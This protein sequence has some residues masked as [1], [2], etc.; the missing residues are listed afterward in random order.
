MDIN[1]P[2]INRE[3]PPQLTMPLVQIK[4]PDQ[5]LIPFG[6]PKWSIER[7]SVV[8]VSTTGTYL[9]SDTPLAYVDRSKECALRLRDFKTVIPG[10]WEDGMD[11][12]AAMRVIQQHLREKCELATSSEK[13]FLDLYFDYCREC[14]TPPDYIERLYE[15]EDERPVP[16]NNMDWMFDAM[17]PLPQAHLYQNDPL[18]DNFHFAP[19]RMMK[20]DF[21]FWTG[22]R[23]IAVEI[24]GSSHSG[25][26]S[27]IRKD[28]LLQRSG[29]HVVH[30]LN[31][32][33]AKHGLKVI[34]RL[35]PPEIT[36]FWK[37]AERKYRSNPLQDLPF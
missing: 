16:Y 12:L 17:M 13:Q 15:K 36:K 29:V 4:I 7:I 10:N 9:Q 26:E 31:G 33:V 30:I 21:A 22:K 34:R 35:L 28:R 2:T 8:G 11:S 19:S 14:V 5:L 1:L 37:S 27:H 3:P 6:G 23:L 25:S 32:E 18:E 20:V 24:D